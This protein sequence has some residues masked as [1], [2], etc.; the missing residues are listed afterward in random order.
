MEAADC[1]QD[2]GGKTGKKQ[3]TKK[4]RIILKFVFDRIG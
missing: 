2:F 3:S 1:V 4:I